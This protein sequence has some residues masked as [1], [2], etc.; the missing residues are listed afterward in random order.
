MCGGEASPGPAGL[1]R[2]R[3]LAGMAAAAGGVLLTR[4]GVRP[5]A[6]ATVDLGGVAVIPRSEWGGDLA[7]AGPIPAEPDARYLLVHHSVDPGNDYA[8]S[9]VAGILRSFVRFHTSPDKGWPD[10]AYNFLVDRFGRVWEGRTGSLAGPV[11]GDATGGNQGF[12]QLC[13]FIGNHQA[14]EPTP[15]A[16]D[17]MVRLLRALAARSG[18]VLGDGATATFTSRGSNRH[19]TGTVVT[20]ATIAGHRDMSRT[21]CPGDRVAARLP[22]LRLL[23]AGGAATS[24]VTTVPRT[25]TPPPAM[26]TTAPAPATTTGPST[27]GPAPT[28]DAGT[29]APVTAGPGS[30]AAAPDA[31]ATGAAGDGDTGAPPAALAAA[32]AA[33]VAAAA[34]A[35]RALGGRRSTA[36]DPPARPGA[37]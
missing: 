1:S 34:G 17:A 36:A 28:L 21:Q 25:T 3:V 16:F 7:P 6:A 20:T 11:A 15:E 10:V 18:I 14:A 2:R 12:D 8:A 37:P 23:A 5:A 22:E 13:C 32:A 27:P 33:T 19:P 4:A 31:Q 24:P 9:D 29:P 30:A 26:S 35:V